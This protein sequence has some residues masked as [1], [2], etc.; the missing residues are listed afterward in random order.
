MRMTS[1]R[2]KGKTLELIA[3]KAPDFIQDLLLSEPRNE[4]QRCIQAEATRLV[5]TFN[6][7]AF[8]V[9]C[10]GRDCGRL[11]LRCTIFKS[12]VL[13][14]W[15]W[16]DTCDP[17]QFGAGR[18]RIQIV[19]TYQDALDFSGAFDDPKVTRDLILTLAEAKG[20]LASWRLSEC[21]ADIFFNG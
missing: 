12:D 2:H 9:S 19:R 21:Q 13:N 10:V 1:G 3:L 6:R 7:R 4:K 11:A 8:C 15:W 17:W 16:C 5:D 14:P 18:D 20:L